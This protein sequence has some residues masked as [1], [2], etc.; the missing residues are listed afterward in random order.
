MHTPAGD[1]SYTGTTCVSGASGTILAPGQTCDL[2]LAFTPTAATTGTVYE[3]LIASA[4]P[5][6]AASGVKSGFVSGAPSSA[7]P[8]IVELSSAKAP[9]DYGTSGSTATL[10]ICNPLGG[11]TFTFGGDSSCVHACHRRGH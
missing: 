7:T 6:T 10:Q 1:F 3:K 4:S 11:T 5:G 8:Y 9:Y 2:V